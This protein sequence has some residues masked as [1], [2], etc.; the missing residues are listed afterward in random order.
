MRAGSLPISDAVREQGRDKNNIETVSPGA[1]NSNVSGISKNVEDECVLLFVR[2]VGEPYCCLGS[3]QVLNCNFDRH[4]IVF[5][6]KL[7][8]YESLL[9]GCSKERFEKILKASPML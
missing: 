9:S 4:P 1:G 8:E 5:H 6:W 2:L 7:V 3:V